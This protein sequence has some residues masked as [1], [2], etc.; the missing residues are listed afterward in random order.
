[1]DSKR[2]RRWASNIG[3]LTEFMEY[4]WTID[5]VQ[6]G[7][8]AYGSLE[9][10][11][12]RS[13]PGLAQTCFRSSKFNYLSSHNL[14]GRNQMAPKYE[15]QQRNHSSNKLC[16]PEEETLYLSQLQVYTKPA[17]LIQD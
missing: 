2:Y 3:F 1:M 10:Y 12:S 6:E 11:M 13:S 8:T 14:D 5:G 17:A 15:A 7:Y 9:S 16:A 4:D